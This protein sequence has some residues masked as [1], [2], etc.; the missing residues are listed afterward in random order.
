VL[1]RD[2]DVVMPRVRPGLVAWTVPAV[3]AAL[4]AGAVLLDRRNGTDVLGD[5]EVLINAPLSLGFAVVGALVVSRR[6]DQGLAW[7]YLGGALAMATTLFVL[8][9]A[10]YGLMTKPG[11]VPGATFAAWMSAWVW[12]L[13]F[14]PLFTLGL[15]LYPDSR[16]PGR[17]WRWAA[18]A[19][20]LAIGCLALN[21]AFAA[22]PLVNHPTTDNPIGLEWA[23]PALRLL[24]WLGYPLML[25]GLTTGVAA[26]AVRWRRAPAEG[27]ERRQIALPLVPAACVCLALLSE[28]LVG[29]E[30]SSGLAIV[31]VTLTIASVPFTIGVAILRHHLYDIDI[32]LNRALVYVG[33]TLGVIALYAA[34]LWALGRQLGGSGSTGIIAT[35][36]VAALVLPL[37][38]ALQRL[39]DRAMYGDRGDPYVALSRL[40][41]RLQGAAE[42]GEALIAI[43]DAIAA[44]LRLPYVEVETADGLR[45]SSGTP[46]SVPL[47]E[48]PLTHLG[49]HV[50]RLLV[51]GRDGRPLS[52]RDEALLTELARPAGAAVF[53]ASLADAL[54]ASRTGLVQAREEERRR[55]RRDLHDGLGPTLA[56]MGL[57]LDVA[58]GLIDR[59][60]A[61]AKDLLADLKREAVEAVDDIRSLVYDLRPPALDELGLVAALRQ[62]AERL[63]L[64]SPGLDVIIDAAPALP[65]LSAATEV[66]AYRI[67]MEA[68]S[69][70]ARHA[71]ATHCRV[72]LRTEDDRLRLEVMD[73]GIGITEG[74][75]AG[76]GIAAMRERAAEIGG[77]CRVGMDGAAGSS[78]VALLPL[79]RA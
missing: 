38:T 59:D 48:W 22:G 29:D 27:V 70:T 52:P 57:G 46:G 60:P 26:L 6:P 11:D 67:A 55:L 13:G 7:L 20:A 50:G 8:V 25:T 30:T 9:Y 40:T 58:S 18:G 54:R 45:A 75:R 39:V 72:Y 32:V 51:E 34:I 73:D 76:V 77:Q 56:G 61:G 15:L 71:Q 10:Q 21:G 35:G 31:L 44:S 1:R 4:V 68:V 12:A 33:L 24:E 78:V 16:L 43:A 74:T 28:L 47:T 36:V 69:N 63:S 14:A 2:N 37:R 23:A 65:R 3:C 19:S 62:Q 41:A 66:A 17:R 42:P 53:A 49:E 64:R 79:E 5:V